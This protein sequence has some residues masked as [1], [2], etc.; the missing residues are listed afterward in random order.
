M[1]HTSLPS[2]TKE[3]LAQWLAENK[4]DQ[5][6]HKQKTELTEDLVH[7]YEA[8]S[9][10]ASRAMDRLNKVKE[11]FMETLK[12]GTPFNQTTEEW[13]PI[14]ITI[15]ASKGLKELEA[16]R[17][18]ADNILEKG[19]TEEDINIYM[20]PWPETSMVIG[21]DVEGV[22]YEQYTRPM[23]ETEISA[24]KPLLRANEEDD[25]DLPL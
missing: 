17:K 9:S 12:T 22:E 11:L 16:N 19:Y 24:Y 3:K 10:L 20:I 13:E 15:P 4:I 25:D 23:S 5:I 1:R 21:V 8:R 14:D 2:Y 6:I 18:F 7:D